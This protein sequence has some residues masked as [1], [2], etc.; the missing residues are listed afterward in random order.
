MPLELRAQH[1]L[2]ERDAAFGAI[3]FPEELGQVAPARRRLVYDE[4]FRLELALALEKRAQI[5][6]A[7]GISHGLSG[8]LVDS[9][10]AGLPYELTGAQRRTLDEIEADLAREHPMHR[11]LQGEVGSGKTVV[12]VASL[13]RAVEGGWQGALMAPTEVL[14]EQHYLGVRQLLADADLSPGTLCLASRDGLAVRQDGPPGE[15]CAPDGF[16]RSQQ[17]RPEPDQSEAC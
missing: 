15:A 13:L 14:A 10:I 17:L 7:E 16:E 4:L 2:M 9:F 5:D 6:A 3:H 8:E 11:L 1:G 12:A